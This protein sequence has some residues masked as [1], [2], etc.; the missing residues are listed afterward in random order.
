MYFARIE[1]GKIVETQDTTPE[2][3]GQF[4]DAYP[5]NWLPVD[6][7]YPH[8]S[9]HY[10]G[11]GPCEFNSFVYHTGAHWRIFPL[12]ARFIGF[13]KHDARY[14]NDRNWWIDIVNHW[15]HHDA[16]S[17]DDNTPTNTQLA[18]LKKI[19]QVGLIEPGAED[20][21]PRWEG[22]IP[23]D[24]IEAVSEYVQFGRVPEDNPHFEG[25]EEDLEPTPVPEE[26]SRL[27]ARLALIE[28]G[29]WQVTKEYFQAPERNDKEVA[30]FEDATVYRRD[31]PVMLAAAEAVGVT[32]EQ[33]DDLFRLAATL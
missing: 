6:D 12:I 17:F 4:P 5:G 31:N 15:W 29:K 9:F 33:L 14:T 10:P 30:F 13:G 26:V 16:L 3:I 22:G 25:F 1:H 24:Q 21:E 27:Q 7:V 23:A 2:L 19:N 28:I 20:E 32:E 18:R 11:T 8:G